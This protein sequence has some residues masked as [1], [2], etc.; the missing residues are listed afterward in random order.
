[1]YIIYKI[2]TP[3]LPPIDIN[4]GSLLRGHLDLELEIQLVSII[5]REGLGISPAFIELHCISRVWKRFQGA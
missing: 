3:S 4:K 2:N 1:M 5:G